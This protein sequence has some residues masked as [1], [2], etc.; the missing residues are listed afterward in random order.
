MHKNATYL[1]PL[2]ICH[3]HCWAQVPPAS[4]LLSPHSSRIISAKAQGKFPRIP[5][6]ST[7]EGEAGDNS[8]SGDSKALK[9]L[10]SPR[11]S[12][13]KIMEGTPRRHTKWSSLSSSGR[14]MASPC[15]AASLQQ[16]FGVCYSCYHLIMS[17]QT[18]PATERKH[19][20]DS[21]F[22]F[23][24]KLC[25]LGLRAGYQLR[26]KNQSQQNRTQGGEKHKGQPEPRGAK[27]T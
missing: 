21:P 14:H 26:A 24:S 27:H 9:P 3:L 12:T 6:G 11:C 17:K 5:T 18:K 7:L 20:K 4:S 10:P 23:P 8:S 25:V 22:T 16:C 15:S 19:S 13:K 1:L 2:L